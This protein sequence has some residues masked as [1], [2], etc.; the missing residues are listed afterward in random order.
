MMTESQPHATFSSRSRQQ[1]KCANPERRAM[2]PRAVSAYIYRTLDARCITLDAIEAR[3]TS[4]IPHPAV[5]QHGNES[6]QR[7]YGREFNSIINA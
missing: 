6:E 3:W 2:R 1:L 7:N 4:S 5:N